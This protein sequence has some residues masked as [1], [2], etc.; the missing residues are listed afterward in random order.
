MA[1]RVNLPEMNSFVRTVV[2]AE[3]MGTPIAEALAIHS[4]DVRFDRVQ[5]AERAALKAPLKILIPL[6]FCIMPTV[7]IIVG[8][9]IFLQFAR[10][11]P[12]AQ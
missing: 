4:D 5:R 11:N 2:Q 1:K 9:P 6:I 10:Q 8:A 7:A 12:F 3:R